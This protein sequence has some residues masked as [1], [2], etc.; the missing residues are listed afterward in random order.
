MKCPKC[1][2]H[3]PMGNAMAMHEGKLVPTWLCSPCGCNVLKENP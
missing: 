2:T 1:N 3:K